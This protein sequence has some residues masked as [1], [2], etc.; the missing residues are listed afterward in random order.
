MTKNTAYTLLVIGLAAQAID[1]FTAKDATGG[2]LFGQNGALRSIDSA[3][4]KATIPWINAQTNLAFWF[5]AA[6]LLIL[7]YKK[8]A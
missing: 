2:V 6:G 4:P 5:I 1:T 3:I 8:W 7:A